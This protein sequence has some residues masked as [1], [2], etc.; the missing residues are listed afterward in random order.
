MSQSQVRSDLKINKVV[1]DGDQEEA[2]AVPKVA[3]PGVRRGDRLD[4]R[5]WR[6]DRPLEVLPARGLRRR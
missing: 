5:L 3:R 6:H 1:R 4:G 2:D